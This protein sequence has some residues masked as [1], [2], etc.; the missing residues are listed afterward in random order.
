M[1]AHRQLDTS[2]AERVGCSAS[3]LEHLGVAPAIFKDFLEWY[4]FAIM[5]GL[6]VRVS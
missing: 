2:Q 5:N 1:V 3:P 4:N 6:R